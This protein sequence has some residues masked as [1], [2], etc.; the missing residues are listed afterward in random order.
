MQLNILIISP[1]KEAHHALSAKLSPD[2]HVYAASEWTTAFALINRRPVQLVIC[3]AGI[4]PTP[5]LL[6]C[7]QLKSN[8]VTAHLP[9]IL[10]T[11]QENLQVRIK[12][13]EAGADVHIGGVIFREH[14]D[15]QI[16]SLIGNRNKVRQYL[17]RKNDD[18]DAQPGLTKDQ[19][20]SKLSNCL[21][22]L[23]ANDNPGID[24]LARMMHMSKP[25]LYRK[26][27]LITN[28]TP[29]ELINEAR[30][31]KAAKLLAAGDHRVAEVARL[32]GYGSPSSF[33]KSFLKQFKVT[34][35]TY[36]RMKKIMD[37]A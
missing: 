24:Q 27:K 32:V 33:G 35:A 12:S 9:V 15:V 6:L 28:L 20:I 18:I 34:P 10:L 2:Y 29:N 19:I 17:T 25:T 31:R 13:L 7:R 23:G 21:F 8:P 5:A 16:R 36:Q 30:L 14:L 1:A 4:S 22:S 11:E 26:M 37:A 3:I